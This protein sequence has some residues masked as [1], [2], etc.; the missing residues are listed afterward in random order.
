MEAKEALKT[1]LN[2]HLGLDAPINDGETA[3]MIEDLEKLG[4]VLCH[5]TPESR[6]DSRG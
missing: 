4:F 1:V 5:V 6:Q 2:D 3:D